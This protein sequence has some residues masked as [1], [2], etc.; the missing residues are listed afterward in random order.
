[1]CKLVWGSDSW[2]FSEVLPLAVWHL[3]GKKDQLYRPTC[4]E[5]FKDLSERMVPFFLPEAMLKPTEKFWVTMLED[6]AKT[7]GSAQEKEEKIP[8]FKAYLYSTNFMVA[9]Q[10]IMYEVIAQPH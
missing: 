7:D 3:V 9:V 1:M 10:S 6:I 8:F 2:V 5:H 4:V